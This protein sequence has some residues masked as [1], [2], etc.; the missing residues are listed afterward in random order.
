MYPEEMVQPMREEV[1]RLGVKECRTAQAVEAALSAKGSALVFINSV[2]GCA[3]GNARPGLALAVRHAAL[4]NRM[5]TVFAGNDGEAVAKARG[6]FKEYPPSSPCFALLKDGKAVHVIPRHDI[7]GR[8][9]QEVAKSLSAAF[10]KH[11][12]SQAGA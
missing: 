11:C 2:C 4:P 6:Y 9:P 5:I 8:T 1:S 7:E 12:A 10:D 3:A